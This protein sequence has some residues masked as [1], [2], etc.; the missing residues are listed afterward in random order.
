MYSIHALSKV[1]VT[2]STWENDIAA[3]ISVTLEDF[4]AARLQDLGSDELAQAQGD[5]E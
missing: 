3:F 4:E 2:L 1:D 5:A